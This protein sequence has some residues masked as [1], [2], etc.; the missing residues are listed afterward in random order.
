[1]TRGEPQSSPSG[2]T[3]DRGGNLVSWELSQW[4]ESDRMHVVTTTTFMRSCS[5]TRVSR[6]SKRCRSWRPA[7]SGFR[8]RTGSRFKLRLVD[9]DS[10]ADGVTRS[11]RLGHGRLDGSAPRGIRNF[12]SPESTY[13]RFARA[14]AAAAKNAALDRKSVV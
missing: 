13:W 5:T 1:M 2:Q 6:A 7:A 9:P 8:S 4:A 11:A 3:K 10:R 12:R 14:A